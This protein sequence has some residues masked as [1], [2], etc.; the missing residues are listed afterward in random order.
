MLCRFESGHWYQIVGMGCRQA[1]RHQVLI[2]ACVGSNP[3]T[4]ATVF[5]SGSPRVKRE[6]TIYSALAQLVEQMTVNHW[7]A[8]SSP[9]GGARVISS[10]GRA[11]PLHGVGRRFEPVITH[12]FAGIAQQVEQLPCKHQVGS[13]ILSAGTNC[14]EVRWT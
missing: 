10:V 3:A 4:P 2:L 7:V 5:W 1:V 9:A 8:G 11:A 14:R 13:S 12:H 6:P